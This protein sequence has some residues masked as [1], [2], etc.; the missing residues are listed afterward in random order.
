MEKKT[1]KTEC[2]VTELNWGCLVDYFEQIA[3]PQIIA[4]SLR[5]VVGFCAEIAIRNGDKLGLYDLDDVGYSIGVV[6]YFTK[7]LENMTI[8]K[9]WKS[10]W[11][12]T[13]NKNLINTQPIELINE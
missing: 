2:K 13:P 11:A 12:I 1:L 10:E 7:A 8:E 5:D 9:D 4:Q 6:S 3:E